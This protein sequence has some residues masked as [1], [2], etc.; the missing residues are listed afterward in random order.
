MS[1]PPYV[2]DYARARLV[3]HL[4]ARIVSNGTADRDELRQF[5]FD[6]T[7]EISD[8]VFHATLETLV[9]AR[10]IRPLGGG[11][12]VNP[13]KSMSNLPA[14]VYSVDNNEYVQIT[15]NDP[16][17]NGYHFVHTYDIEP[18]SVSDHYS[19]PELLL[20]ME[21][22]VTNI[23]PDQVSLAA[24]ILNEIIGI[25]PN[26]LNRCMDEQRLIPHVIRRLAKRPEIIGYHDV[27]AYLTHPILSRYIGVSV[28]VIDGNVVHRY[29]FTGE[30]VPSKMELEEWLRETSPAA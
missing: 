3:S 14:P 5:I 25:V 26:A 12:V 18:L 11:G 17:L 9:N 15:Q 30:N 2:C 24:H 20:K 16:K 29:R 19:S 27:K 7:P 1:Q 4:V 6:H 28:S 10:L 22:S 13:I 8:S 21:E 23:Q